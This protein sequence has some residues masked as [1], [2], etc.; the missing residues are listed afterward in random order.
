MKRSH[1]AIAYS[2]IPYCASLIPVKITS[3]ILLLSSKCFVL[4]LSA[5]KKVTMV[6]EKNMNFLL[7]P[8]SQK[9]KK[10]KKQI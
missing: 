9:V 5:V 6:N 7:I 10:N 3:D 8:K 4:F 2:P 1:I